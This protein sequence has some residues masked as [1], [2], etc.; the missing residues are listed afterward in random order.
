MRQQGKAIIF[1]LGHRKGIVIRTRVDTDAATANQTHHVVINAIQIR[2]DI[3]EQRFKRIRLRPVAAIF[4]VLHR[5]CQRAR[6]INMVFMRK[7]IT[8]VPFGGFGAIHAKLLA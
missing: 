8:I 4:A 7:H 1:A 5:P 3:I 2:I 6:V